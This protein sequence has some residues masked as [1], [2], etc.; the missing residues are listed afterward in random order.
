VAGGVEQHSVKDLFVA[1][2]DSRA[3]TVRADQTATNQPSSSDAWVLTRSAPLRSRDTASATGS[4]IGSVLSLSSWCS[5]SSSDRPDP[6]AC[7]TEAQVWSTMIIPLRLLAG[8]WRGVA[9]S[10]SSA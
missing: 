9:G 10:S 1:Q 8:G 6:S 5:S 3:C 4:P 7:G 2:R